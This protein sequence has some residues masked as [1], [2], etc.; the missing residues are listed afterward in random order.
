MLIEAF[1]LDAVE[2]VEDPTAEAVLKA[3]IADWL[4]GPGRAMEAA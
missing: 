2:K 3:A 4:A 1:V